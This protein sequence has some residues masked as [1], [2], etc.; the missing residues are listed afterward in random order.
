[1][2]IAP[3]VPQFADDAVA[4]LRERI[5]R[6]RWPR[7]SDPSW[8]RGVPDGYLRELAAYWADG[9]DWDVYAEQLRRWPQYRTEID[10]QVIHFA[11]VRSSAAGAV[12]L[13]MTHGWPGSYLEFLRVAEPLTEPT[14][15]DDA[16]DLVLPSLPGYGFSTPLSAPGWGVT[17]IATAFAELMARLGYDR[18]VAQGGDWGSIITREIAVRDPEHV[19]GVHLNSGFTVPPRGFDPAGLDEI[20]AQRWRDLRRYDRELSGY[21]HLQATRPRTLAY[22]L[23]DSP[24]GQLAWIAE[25]FFEWTDSTD[26]PED[27]VDRDHLLAD[28]SLY[29]LTGTAGSSADLYYEAAHEPWPSGRPTPPVGMSLFQHDMPLPIRSLTE[30][31]ASIVSWREHERG[32]HFAAMEQ[33][34][35]LVAD[36]RD[37]TRT[38]GAR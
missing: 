2:T 17:R 1:V 9:F 37:F 19:L 8:A 26:R 16:F 34:A 32:G 36:I 15:V 25:K 27:A 11:H 4:D 20:D 29:W 13:I 22:A 24:V 10:G 12:P 21:R 5:R 18:Y 31:S 3:F 33:P 14:N 6:T 38:I 28:V 23:T 35:T 30:E 7:E